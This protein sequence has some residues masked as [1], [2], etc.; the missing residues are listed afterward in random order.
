MSEIKKAAVRRVYWE[1]PECGCEFDSEEAAL[2][3]CQGTCPRC[4]GPLGR[5]RGFCEMCKKCMSKIRGDMSDA[6]LLRR[7]ELGGHHE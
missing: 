7:L 5:C 4:G 3:C 1:C 6:E 2:Q